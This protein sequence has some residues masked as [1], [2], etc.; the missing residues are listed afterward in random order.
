MAMSL[1]KGGSVALGLRLQQARQRAGL[2][3]QELCQKSGLSYS[4]LA[5][6]ERGA[7]KS[8]SIFTVQQIADV[9]STSI[10]E[11]TG[12]LSAN[13]PDKPA[14]KT[15]KTGISFVYFDING[16]LVS[17]FHRAFTKIAVDLH[18]PLDAVENVCWHY[19][20]A[21]CRGDISLDEY[22]ALLAKAFNVDTFDWSS[23]YLSAVDPIPEAHELLRW[24]AEHYKVG[25]LSNIM[26]GLIEEMRSRSLIPDLAYDAV[27]GSSD[28]KAIKP[29][30]EI[31]AAATQKAG[32]PPEQIL[33]VDDSRA[34]LM[35]AEKTGWRVSWFDDF[36]PKESSDRVR[37]ALEF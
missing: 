26:P 16:C 2:T 19:N 21:V 27:I 34:N 37:Q 18:L 13:I 31:F 24:T 32:V 1:E 12:G 17:F 33:F 35:V 36:R 11:L 14:K 30:P 7:I 9:L 29:E 28:V 23:Y 25:L 10:D 5:K 8:P 3:Q 6:I 20:D 4:T 22:N 15:S